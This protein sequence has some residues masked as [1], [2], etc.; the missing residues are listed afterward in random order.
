[1]NAWYYVQEGG[2][3]HWCRDV[4]HRIAK[5]TR[6][7]PN[8]QK[9]EERARQSGNSVLLGTLPIFHSVAVLVLLHFHPAF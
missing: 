5:L 2:M 4:P 8:K 3:G 7:P 1:M 9:K 6:P